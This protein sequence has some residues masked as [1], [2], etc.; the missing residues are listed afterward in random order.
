MD[1]ADDPREALEAL[2]ANE[3]ERDPSLIVHAA[4][5]FN[6]ETPPDVLAGNFTTPSEL[7]YVRNHLPVPTIDEREFRLIVDVPGRSEELHLTLEDL[8]TRFPRVTV[9]ATLQ[10]A[11]NR[12]QEM[13]STKPVKGLPWG[14]GAMGNAVWTGA[15]LSDV[16]KAA[17]YMSEPSALDPDIAA[18]KRDGLLVT[19]GT[20]VDETEDARLT[21][22]LIM[23]GAEGYGAS[24]PVAKALNPLADVV[25]AYEM[26]GQPL[27]R[28]H[29]APLRA[30]VPGHVAA[31]SV[32]WLRR[33]SVSDEESESHWQRRDYK[34]FGPSK[35]LTE[36]RY[37]TSE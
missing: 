37:E 6:A 12:R 11:G 8:K 25:L 21:R 18:G 30:V 16:L 1:D 3:P 27:L 2:F 9:M 4:T 23:D 28:D 29:G 26:N 17:G 7:F 5:P 10:C 34:G 15:R 31:R 14:S 32:K 24:I 22:H 20:P 13:N 33:I 35:S 36:S 19:A